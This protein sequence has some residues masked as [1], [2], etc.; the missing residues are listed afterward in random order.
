MDTFVVNADN[1]QGDDL[2]PPDNI[3]NVTATS[4][5]RLLWQISNDHLKYDNHITTTM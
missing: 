2:F 3:S 1:N 5:W 4:Y